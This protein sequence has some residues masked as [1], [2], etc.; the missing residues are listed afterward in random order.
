MNAWIQYRLYL[1]IN[2]YLNQSSNEVDHTICG[3]KKVNHAR[4]PTRIQ[5][6]IVLSSKYK[7]NAQTKLC[8]FK[9]LLSCMVFLNAQL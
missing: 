2:I 7:L 8:E 5:K 4:T 1:C 9:R 3:D 6:P